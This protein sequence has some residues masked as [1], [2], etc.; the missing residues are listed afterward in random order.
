MKLKRLSALI[1]SLVM[2]LSL[3]VAAF[4][5]DITNAE[6]GHGG[7]DVGGKVEG[8]YDTNVYRVRLPYVDEDTK[9]FDFI[10]DPMGALYDTRD[11]QNYYVIEDATLYFM[12]AAAEYDSHDFYTGNEDVLQYYSF[13][14]SSESD[15]LT[16]VNKSSFDVRA[17]VAATADPGSFGNAQLVEDD[18]FAYYGGLDATS[19]YLAL[20]DA[21]ETKAISAANGAQVS[22]RVPKLAGAYELT[23]ESDGDNNSYYYAIKPEVEADPTAFASCEYAF[24]LSGK[25]NG[26][27]D[28]SKLGNIA[29]ELEVTWTVEAWED[30][31]APAMSTLTLQVEASAEDQIIDLSELSG[32]NAGGGALK[33]T[34]I[35]KIEYPEGMSVTKQGYV[36]L[37]S[38]TSIKLTA[39][40]S[41]KF[42][43]NELPDYSVTL[44]LNNPGKTEVTLNVVPKP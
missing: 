2:V 24:Y 12:N 26:A 10:L 13:A 1:L 21:D 11:D 34:A 39:A 23:T 19:I 6:D 30:D 28:W 36:T 14:L 9:T 15:K 33:A 25:C 44:V 41:S 18:D 8:L 32:W 3:S 38:G 20:K 7:I 16:I 42:A 43:A 27:A 17:S 4:A 5:D 35:S 37:A 31:A 29:P 22:G 40:G